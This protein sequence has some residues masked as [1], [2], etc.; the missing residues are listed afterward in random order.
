MDS[1]ILIIF[2]VVDL[3]LALLAYKEAEKRG[4]DKYQ[5][6]ILVLLL[7]LIPLIVLLC[8][9]PETQCPDCKKKVPKDAK[10]CAYCGKKFK[11]T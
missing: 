10:L 2:F 4:R 5:W 7:G 6:A 1:N 3:L 11:M 9:S 8:L